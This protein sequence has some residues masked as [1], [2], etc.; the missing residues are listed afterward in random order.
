MS[1][2]LH[3]HSQGYWAK[4]KLEESRGLGRTQL[5]QLSVQGASPSCLVPCSELHQDSA[6]EPDQR[7]SARVWSWKD[8]PNCMSARCSRRH[9]LTQIYVPSWLEGPPADSAIWALLRRR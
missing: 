1:L 9:C 7:P 8:L 6:A 2:H 3:S 4:L 5:R